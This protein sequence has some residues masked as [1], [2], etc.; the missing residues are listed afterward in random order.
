MQV[1][2]SFA[3]FSEE[4]DLLLVGDVDFLLG[5]PGEVAILH[6]IHHNRAINI[7]VYVEQA[8]ALDS[9]DPVMHVE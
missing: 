1:G 6:Q 8:D 3:D 7:V 9:Q 5:Q 2:E 4:P